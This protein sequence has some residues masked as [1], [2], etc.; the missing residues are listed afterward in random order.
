M[1]DEVKGNNKD[2]GGKITNDATSIMR[3]RLWIQ[4]MFVI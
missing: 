1:L 4:K 3:G 2:L